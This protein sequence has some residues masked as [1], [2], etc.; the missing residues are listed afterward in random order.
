[1]PG[2]EPQPPKGKGA[3]GE[4]GTTEEE[5][6]EEEAYEEV[7]EGFAEGLAA[8]CLSTILAPPYACHLG[9]KGWAKGVSMT[10]PPRSGP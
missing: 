7:R 9:R 6:E 5:E 1:M 4:G 10:L 8:S 2:G 3:D